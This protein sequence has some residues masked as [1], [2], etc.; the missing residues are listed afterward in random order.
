MRG[1]LRCRPPG[2]LLAVLVRGQAEGQVQGRGQVALLLQ[3]ASVY[4][5]NGVC[6]AK[7]GTIVQAVKTWLPHRTAPWVRRPWQ[8]PPMARGPPLRGGRA[9]CR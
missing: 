9:R 7:S 5:G 1:A 6:T 4:K 2:N 3:K 8:A